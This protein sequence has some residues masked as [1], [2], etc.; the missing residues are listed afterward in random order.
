MSDDLS[1]FF[2]KKKEKAKEKKKKGVN[3]EEVG[4]Q[5]ERK[6]KR[7]E[8][9]DREDEEEEKRQQDEENFLKQ[10]SAEDSEW[11][12]YSAEG[13]EMRLTDLGIRDMNIT[14]QGEDPGEEE[15]IVSFEPTK[16]WN[17]QSDGNKDPENN[18]TEETPI[19]SKKP[20]VY[21]PPSLK[22]HNRGS[23]AS[24]I[25]LDI[26]NQEAF[27]SFAAA[28]EMEKHQRDAEKN[29]KT[30]KANEPGGESIVESAWNKTPQQNRAERQEAMN[31]VRDMTSR[32]SPTLTPTVASTQSIA[33]K[34]G[35]YVPPSRRGQT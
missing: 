2:A 33:P 23:P 28:E 16:S 3:I 31:A 13:R 7:Q 6:A 1:E 9:R 17:I 20:A 34:P 8:A 27:P 32:A 14:E 12:D 19:M 35:V 25:T 18:K 22:Y 29:K 10:R 4:Q 11:L 5:L 15:K 26:N 24:N 30:R 21:V